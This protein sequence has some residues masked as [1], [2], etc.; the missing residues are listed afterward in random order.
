[1]TLRYDRI[2]NFW[3]CML[4][5]LAHI[6]RHIETGSNDFFVDDLELS[7]KNK[8]EDEADEWASEALVPKKIWDAHPVSNVPNSNNVIALAHK[9]G[10]HPAVV[11]GRV[12]YVSGNYQ[13]L[14][15]F[16]GSG[17][18]RKYLRYE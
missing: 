4:H 3:F 13:L 6:G 18:V 5:E 9:L 7:S 11:A 8:F 17:E 14:S 16:V 15:A 10:V 12:R 1:V 2:D